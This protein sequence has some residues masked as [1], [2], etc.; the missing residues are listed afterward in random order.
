MHS[1]TQ[2]LSKK[3]SIFMHTYS[4]PD[5]PKDESLIVANSYTISSTQR[6]KAM[7][8]SVLHK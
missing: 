3:Q 4:D 6:G 1:T 2:L 7:E 5:Y 8:S